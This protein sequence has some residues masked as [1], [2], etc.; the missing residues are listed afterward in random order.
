[1]EK[2]TYLINCTNPLDYVNSLQEIGNKKQKLWNGLEIVSAVPNV[3]SNCQIFIKNDLHFYRTDYLVEDKITLKVKN[4][5]I[6]SQYIDFRINKFGSTVSMIIDKELR[7]CPTQKKDISFHVYLKKELLCL[8]KEVLATKRKQAAQ[9]TKLNKISEEILSI[10][11]TGNKNA[12]RVEGK[13]LELSYAY[14]EYLH[15]PIINVPSFLSCDY[16]LQC[17][18]DAKKIL[19][20]TFANPP[21]IKSLSKKVGINCNQL[22]IGFKHLF[23]TTIRQFVINLRL[24]HAQQLILNTR[25]PLSEVCHTVGYTNHGH[26]SNLYKEKFG[27][28]PIKDRKINSI[29]TPT[30]K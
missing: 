4:E 9:C 6:D 8:N 13:M 11:A 5:A 2:N 30:K 26:F 10:P 7:L 14:L 15:A 27:L 16:K 19:E 28:S 22:K 23:S 3:K 24:E 12:L 25:R 18:Y 1:M 17:I 21:T 29:A 20:D